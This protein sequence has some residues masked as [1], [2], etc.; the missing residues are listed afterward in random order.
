MLRFFYILEHPFIFKVFDKKLINNDDIS[1]L[2]PLT[3]GDCRVDVL[4]L[5]VYQC[6]KAFLLNIAVNCSDILLKISLKRFN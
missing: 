4:T 1:A 5:P 6:K 2:L 3:V